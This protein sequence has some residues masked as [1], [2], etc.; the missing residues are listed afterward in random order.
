M[1]RFAF[2]LIFIVSLNGCAK[3]AT[4]DS[5]T[6]IAVGTVVHMYDSLPQECKN[7]NSEKLR[8]TALEQIQAITRSCNDE[9][10]LLRAKISERNLIILVLSGIILLYFGAKL[11]S[12][13]HL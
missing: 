1:K 6:D 8:D 5:M 7:K 12:R 3:K 9:K 10:S 13:L 2:L 11:S 4:S